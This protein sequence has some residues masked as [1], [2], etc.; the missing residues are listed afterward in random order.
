MVIRPD[1]TRSTSRRRSPHP[2]HPTLNPVISA[3]E[4]ITSDHRV[5]LLH[6][7]RAAGYEN[8]IRASTP[9]C[10]RIVSEARRRRAGLRTRAIAGTEVPAPH[11]PGHGAGTEVR[12][13]HNP[14]HRA[15]T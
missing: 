7:H 14:G 15:G 2:A 9:G 11:N 1:Y 4:L 8:N 10:D 12:A 13:P 5:G 6:S 3:T